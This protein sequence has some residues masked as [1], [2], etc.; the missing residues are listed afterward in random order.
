[1]TRHPVRTLVNNAANRG[2]ICY[3]DELYLVAVEALLRGLERC[4]DE[5]AVLPVTVQL[6]SKA[7]REKGMAL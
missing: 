6:L 5:G 2:A 7:A 1:M 3:T 4:A